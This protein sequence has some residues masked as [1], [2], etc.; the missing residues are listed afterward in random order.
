MASPAVGTTT[1]IAA[2]GDGSGS[3]LMVL[4]SNYQTIVEID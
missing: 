3:S 4:G 1:S 2:Q